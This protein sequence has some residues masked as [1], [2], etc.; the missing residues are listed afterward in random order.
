M[1]LRLQALVADADMNGEEATNDAD[2]QIADTEV[3][4]GEDGTEAKLEE[5]EE[6]PVVG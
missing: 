4:A 6:E 1:A 2:T 3:N 5:K